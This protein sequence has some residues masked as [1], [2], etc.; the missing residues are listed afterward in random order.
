MSERG[1]TGASSRSTI[2]PLDRS[3]SRFQ[4]LTLATASTTTPATIASTLRTTQLGW[5]DRRPGTEQCHPRDQQGRPGA[6]EEG[7]LDDQRDVQRVVVAHEVADE[8]DD[9]ETGQHLMPIG[10][11]DKENRGPGPDARRPQRNQSQDRGA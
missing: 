6:R 2:L 3:R 8:R 10:E 5:R 1:S 11:S 4:M 9:A 7:R